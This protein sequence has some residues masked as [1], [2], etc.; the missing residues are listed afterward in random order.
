MT[1]AVTESWGGRV[2]RDMVMSFRLLASCDRDPR[3]LF[4]VSFLTGR[5]GPAPRARARPERRGGWRGTDFL[6]RE[7]RRLAGAGKKSGARHC[8]TARPGRKRRSEKA[9]CRGLSPTIARAV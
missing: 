4:G 6:F 3:G 7:E 9:A 8:G 2:W 5:D 1:A